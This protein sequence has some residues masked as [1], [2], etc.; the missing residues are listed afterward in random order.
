[1]TNTAQ[2]FEGM[3]GNRATL[4]LLERSLATG[5]VAHA[6]LF[7]G[8]A[9]VGKRTAARRFGA[10]LVAGGDGAAEDRARRGLH[11]DLS[12]VRPEGAFTTI[13][14][15]REILR[16][17]SGRPFEGAR[18]VFIL[19]AD[20]LRTEAANALLKTLEEPEGETV[21]VLLA[22]SREGVMPTI[23]SRARAV[24]FNPVPTVEIEGF[25][26]GRGAAEPG[27]A[28]A[29]GR[30]S[31][32]LALRYAEDRE[33]QELRETVFGAAF[34]VVK[35]FEGRHGAVEGIVGRAEALGA[36]REK[37]ALA[38]VEEPDRR[39]KDGAKRAGRAARDGAVREA[40]DLLALTY[41]DAAAVSVGAEE[42]AANVDRVEEL[43]AR[44]DEH[45]GAD[46]AGAAQ[47]LGEARAALAYNVSPEAILEVALSRIRRKVLE[48]FP[49]SST[50]ASRAGA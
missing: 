34:S 49:G 30:G 41:R 3:I 7:F 46:W 9:G 22:G 38:A 25:L 23:L 33:L 26:R 45:P 39:A 2:T 31:V 5:E 10:T 27:L 42:L 36:A 32:G 1:M 28:A 20:T 11:P 43:Q 8:P 15:V 47:V 37:E 13:G 48:P 29:L 24:R 50:S 44:V 40:M 35:D 4:R 17:A 6:Y 19:E 21:F 16:L 12:E 14:Q 18:R